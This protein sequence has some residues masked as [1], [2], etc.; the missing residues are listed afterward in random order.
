[1]VTQISKENYFGTLMCVLTDETRRLMRSMDKDYKLEQKAWDIN[2]EMTKAGDWIDHI[3][4]G[5]KTI[6]HT[7][8][9]QFVQDAM[10]KVLPQYRK[11]AWKLI[12]HFKK[13]AIEQGADKKAINEMIEKRFIW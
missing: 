1:M 9:Q 4:G 11:L 7:V 8:P 5:F 10:Q 6:V 2:A 12:Q 3:P 13:S